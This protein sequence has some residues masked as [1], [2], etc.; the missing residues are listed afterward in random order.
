MIQIC[1]T[2]EDL[3]LKTSAKL[4]MSLRKQNLGKKN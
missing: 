3:N 1:K 4:A 2:F